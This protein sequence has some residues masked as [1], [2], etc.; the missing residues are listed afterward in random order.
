MSKPSQAGLHSAEYQ[1]QEEAGK[2][3]E[4]D[5]ATD[6]PK[7]ASTISYPSLP[8]YWEDFIACFT[9]TKASHFI[10]QSFWE[11][12]STE[13]ERWMAA[14]ETEMKTLK[15]KHTGNLVKP[16]S[17]ANVIGSMWIYNIKWDGE[18]NWIKD[19]AR[20]VGKGYTQQLGVDYNETWAA[21]MRLKSVHMTATI[22]A[23]L[24]LQLWW[25]DLIGAY[26]NSIKKEDI[27]MRQPEGFVEPGF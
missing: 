19:K 26:L 24:D 2:E 16:P 8:E 1:Q 4:Q 12:M 3:G 13:P 27:Y 14:M 7:A 23:K 22:A 11:A 6:H 15:D 10:P 9:D 25:L 17:G 21:V 5:W 20:L 18:G